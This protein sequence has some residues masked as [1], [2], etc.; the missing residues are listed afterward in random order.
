MESNLIQETN[1]ILKK[2]RYIIKRRFD[3]GLSKISV[4]ELLL[5]GFN[6]DYFTSELKHE[7]GLTLFRFVYE[8]GVGET[9]DGIFEII[10]LP[11]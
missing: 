4:N 1:S 3:S 6:P 2:N 8:Y 10:K 9:S 7:N 5:E 11:I